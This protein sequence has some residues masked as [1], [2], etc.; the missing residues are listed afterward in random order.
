M[1]GGYLSGGYLSG[2]ICPRIRWATARKWDGPQTFAYFNN[3]FASQMRLSNSG[4][5]EP[6]Y[7][8]A[9]MNWRRNDLIFLCKSTPIPTA[10]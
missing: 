8:P 10:D 9:P 5:Y 7:G 1:S 2:G 6:P 4:A 3:G